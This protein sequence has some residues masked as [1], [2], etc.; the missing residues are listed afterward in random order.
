MKALVPFS[1]QASASSTAVVFM[2][3][4]SEPEPGS[5]SAHAPSTS[6]RQSGG[7][8]RCR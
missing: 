3:A 1:T 2:A 8:Y 5:V 6:P 4:A 7:R